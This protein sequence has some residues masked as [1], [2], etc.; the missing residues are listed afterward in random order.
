[1]DSTQFGLF[2]SGL[3]RERG[4]TQKELAAYLN[5]TDKAVSK[6]ETGK[7]FPDI[8][9]MEP[10]AD[11]LGVSLLEL[12]QCRRQEQDSLT[13]AQAEAVISQA[14]DQSQKITALRYL[15]LLRW[16]LIGIALLAAYS[17]VTKLMEYAAV[18]FFT[19][20]FAHSPTLGS[21]LGIIGGADGPTAILTTSTLPQKL[22][23]IGLFASALMCVIMI[24]CIVMAVKVRKLE[25]K[26]K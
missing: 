15:R 2:L 16:L 12:I 9:L 25:K 8:K 1:M 26:M 19:W 11:A 5:V 13:V 24:A 3:R 21:D 23:W 4:M 20:Y 10:L 14:M 6:W 7:G 18:W 22:Y 17:P